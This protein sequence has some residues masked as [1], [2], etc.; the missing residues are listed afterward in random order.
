MNQSTGHHIVDLLIKVKSEQYADLQA[1]LQAEILTKIWDNFIKGLTATLPRED[2]SKF[3]LY[4]CEHYT[5]LAST[6]KCAIADM[7]GKWLSNEIATQTK[8]ISLTDKWLCL[9]FFHEPKEEEAVN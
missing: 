4:Q 5:L 2:C 9:S 3:R 1:D 7:S 8:N 6:P